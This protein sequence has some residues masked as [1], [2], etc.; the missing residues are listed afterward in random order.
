MTEHQNHGGSEPA[1]GSGITEVVILRW[2]SGPDERHQPE[3]L[4]EGKK[5]ITTGPGKT[6]QKGKITAEEP[7]RNPGRLSTTLNW[8]I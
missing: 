5:R 8:R 7:K 4:R 6:V 1:D 3:A 2:I